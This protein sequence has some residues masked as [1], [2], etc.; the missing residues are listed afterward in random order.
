LKKA[1]LLL[2]L[3]STGITF[4]QTKKYSGIVKTQSDNIPLPGVNVVVKGTKIGTQTDL[5]GYFKINIPDT[6]NILNFSYVGMI[7]LDYK[8]E[9]EKNLEIFLK[10]D[11]NIDWFDER[12]IGV[13][14]NSGLIN[15]PVGGLFHF[16]FTPNYNWPTIKTGISYQT[17]LEE[18][19][20]LNA[21]MNFHHLFVSCDF[22]ADLNS[23][24]RKLNYDKNIEL[25]AFS[26]ETS[27]NFKRYSAIV[28]LSAIDFNKMSENKNINSIGPT[29]GLGT[30]I[31]QPFLM[32]VSA[33]T[34][35]YKNLS[36]Y[37]AEIKKR[38]KGIYGFLKYYR[39]NDFNELSL[40][41]GIELAY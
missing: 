1:L 38:Y 20:F 39:V 18:N 33:K 4:C 9:D 11:C 5:N 24:F 7:S 30:W 3:F 29:F 22:N 36:E 27:L 25:N 35:I 6:L 16:S 17:N 8:V 21:Y 14:F 28:G 32:S 31:G 10:E 23:S 37:H 26:F 41:I 2:L 12:H 13:Y 34:S 15:N 19:K 40:G